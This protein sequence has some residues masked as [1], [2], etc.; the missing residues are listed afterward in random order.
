MLRLSALIS[1]IRD[2]SLIHGRPIESL[3]F[4]TI[5][6]KRGSAPGEG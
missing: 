6:D 4:T 1:K 2:K 5:R 3:D